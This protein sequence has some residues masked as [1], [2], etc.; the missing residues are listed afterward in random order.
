MSAVRQILSDPVARHLRP[1]PTRV[2]LGV[3]AAE[4]LEYIRSHP[5]SGRIVYFYVVD[6]EDRLRG[7]IPARRLLMAD[8]HQRVDDLMIRTVIAIPHTA[9]VLETCEF[10]ILHKL[11]AFPVVDD[12]GRLI[13]VVDV[14]L[15]TDE[16]SDLERR[17]GNDDLFQLIGVHL[18][19]AEARS[20]RLQFRR[21]F[22]WLLANVAGG[23]LAALLTGMYEDVATLAVVTPFI[24]VVLA[25]AESVSIQSVSLTIQALHAGRP[26][27]PE[28]LRR[29]AR[30]LLV[31]L[32]LGTA[33]G[34]IVGGLS[35][36]WKGSPWVGLSLW[37]GIA[38]AV[39]FAA[40]IGL[41]MPILLRI[42][43][44]D[45]SV[46]SGP[47]ALAS[48]DMVTLVVYFNLAR[49]LLR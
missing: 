45:P 34:L 20:V 3:T 28:F 38:G 25:L 4:A 39:M 44:Y 5:T 17:E 6:D 2:P 43:R 36:V 40:G 47:I 48:A 23:L 22:P 49:W 29:L 7:V 42:F 30:E 8:P 19:E 24:P 37:G 11:L 21:R 1:D 15:Y 14:D 18:S 41:A 35:V 9:T 16:L 12:D 46:A 10:F 26:S 13:G 32:S 31:G 27:W 33:C